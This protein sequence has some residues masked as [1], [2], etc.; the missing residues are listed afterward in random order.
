MHIGKRTLKQ[1][2]GR[3]NEFS[4]RMCMRVMRRWTLQSLSALVMVAFTKPYHEISVVTQI[5][6]SQI[7]AIQNSNHRQEHQYLRGK[8]FLLKGKNH[9][10]NFK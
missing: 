4:S 2:R 6:L 10:T 7:L 8:P 3:L 5:I 9:R 1:G